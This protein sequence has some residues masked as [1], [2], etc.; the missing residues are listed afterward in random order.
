MSNE[1]F[2]IIVIQP[3]NFHICSGCGYQFHST[4]Q[5]YILILSSPTINGQQVESLFC[6]PHCLINFIRITNNLIEID[7]E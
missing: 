2:P 3:I 7:S 1:G 6:N 5:H 4:A